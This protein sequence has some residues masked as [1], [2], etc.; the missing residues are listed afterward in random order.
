MEEAD[1]VVGSIVRKKDATMGI[2]EVLGDKR[3]EV[4]RI[5]TQN[6]A[7]SVRVFGSA[8]RGEADADSDVDFLVELEKG[9]S[10]S[11]LGGMLMDLQE[12]LGRKVDVVTPKGL[13]ARIGDDVLAQAVPL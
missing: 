13:R 5:A 11:D 1:P 2:E 6:G 9:C 12:L 10:L 3:D 7:T 8:V 4:L